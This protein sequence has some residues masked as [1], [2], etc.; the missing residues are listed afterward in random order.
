MIDPVHFDVDGFAARHVDDA[1]ERVAPEQRALR[2]AHEFDL[3][4]IE[5]LDVRR[6]AVQLRHAVDDRS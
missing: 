4:D 5:Q 3:I 1:A 2:P 6:V